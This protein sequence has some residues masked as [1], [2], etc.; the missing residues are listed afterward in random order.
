MKKQ[1]TIIRWDDERGFGFIRSP[2]TT[3]DIFFHIR[4]FHGGDPAGLRIGLP[5]TFE[6][7]HVGGK[8]PRA[9]AVQDGSPRRAAAPAHPGARTAARTPA[10]KPWHR[11]HPRPDCRATSSAGTWFTLA[12]MAG[13]TAA[14]FWAVWH[15][16]LPWWVLPASVLLNMAT[17]FVYWVDKYAAQ[18]RH[19]RTPEV[20]LHAWALAGGWGGAWWAQRILR[21][22]V[23]K[24]SF[25]SQYWLAVIVHCAAV[26]A[27]LY[28][29]FF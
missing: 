11:P 5:V 12:L 14:L 7:I 4:D 28:L 23:S 17:F 1:G 13:Y 24:E 27:W 6:E 15:R 16:H 2:Q 3:A 21:H 25:M 10:R 9:V 8:G 19:W 26:G 22:K 20:H 29:R 18:Q